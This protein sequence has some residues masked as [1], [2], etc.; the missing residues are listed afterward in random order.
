MSNICKID[1][2]RTNILGLGLDSAS[3]CAAPRTILDTKGGS[4]TSGSVVS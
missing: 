1:T 4:Y 2:D 3:V